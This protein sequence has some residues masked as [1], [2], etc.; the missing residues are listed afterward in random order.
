MLFRFTRSPD[1]ENRFIC[2]CGITILAVRSMTNHVHGT[3]TRKG[4]TFISQRAVKLAQEE[5]VCLDE[6]LFIHYVPLEKRELF[7]MR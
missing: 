3:S 4:C 5:E 1:M 2:M 7:K 6:N